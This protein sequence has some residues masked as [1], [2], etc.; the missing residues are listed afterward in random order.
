MSQWTRSLEVVY[1]LV[2]KIPPPDSWVFMATKGCS[3]D[4]PWNRLYCSN[5]LACG[6]ED[7]TAEAWQYFSASSSH[8]CFTSTLFQHSLGYCFG[9]RLP[10]LLQI[11]RKSLL[12]LKTWPT[13]RGELLNSR[14]TATLH[15]VPL[16]LAHVPHRRVGKY[17][18]FER[19]L[20]TR[21]P[22]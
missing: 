2:H 9:C 8:A 16:P 3:N 1:R 18:P 4:I 22:N 7:R 20:V 11:N 15:G 10:L 21:Y 5:L 17:I 19:T 12:A 14:V 13:L 6:L